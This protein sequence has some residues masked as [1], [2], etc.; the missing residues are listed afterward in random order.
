[1]IGDLA[2]KRPWLGRGLN[3]IALLGVAAF[4][5]GLDQLTKYWVMVTLPE[6]QWWSPLSGGGWHVFRITHT[7][8]SGAAF[9]IFPQQGG[10]FILIAVVVVVAI[11]LYYRH[12]PQG[13][14]L[15]RLSLGLQLGG[16]IG[17]LIDRLRFGYVVDFIDVGFWPIFNVADAS[18]TIGVIVIAYRL[19]RGDRVK[20]GPVPGLTNPMT[21]DG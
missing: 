11:L 1:M 12:L 17:N 9:G 14:W 6:G 16:A 21:D 13:D 8:N 20:T 18:I 4:V 10:I 3:P 19:W 5:I 15:I 2:M 7:T